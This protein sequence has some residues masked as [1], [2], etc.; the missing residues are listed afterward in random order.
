ML[1]KPQHVARQ[2]AFFLGPQS[3]VVTGSVLDF[4]QKVVGTYPN[5][6]DS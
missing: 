4:D 6:D 5:T 1:V 3:G 2:V